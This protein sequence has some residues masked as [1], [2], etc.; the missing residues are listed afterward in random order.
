MRIKLSYRVG[1]KDYPVWYDVDCALD[2]NRGRHKME[3]EGKVVE[4][5]TMD[6]TAYKIKKVIRDSISVPP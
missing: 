1:R 3:Y 4:G 2:V 5:K 6:E